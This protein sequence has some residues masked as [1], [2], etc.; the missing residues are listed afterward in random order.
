MSDFVLQISGA[1]SAITLEPVGLI[2]GEGARTICSLNVSGSL[3]DERA[4]SLE[5][6]LDRVTGLTDD[7]WRVLATSELPVEA[8]ASTAIG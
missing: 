2:D 4:A 3:R 5:I 8:L 6:R 7:A 1:G